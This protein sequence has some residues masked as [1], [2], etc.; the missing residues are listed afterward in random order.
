[1]LSNRGAKKST[2]EIKGWL[3]PP[4]IH[5]SKKLQ[6]LISY[7]P[8]IDRLF[9]ILNLEN[10]NPKISNLGKNAHKSSLESTF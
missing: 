7:R 9:E 3:H 8:L 5:I 4:K 6:T 1:M 2:S 10:Q